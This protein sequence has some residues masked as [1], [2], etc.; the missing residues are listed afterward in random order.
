V[1]KHVAE[2]IPHV[3]WEDKTELATFLSRDSN[4]QANS[5]YSGFT[6]H[7]KRHTQH[8]GGVTPRYRKSSCDVIKGTDVVKIRE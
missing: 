6:L 7:F 1:P 8:T 3:T 5:E 2:T 4:L